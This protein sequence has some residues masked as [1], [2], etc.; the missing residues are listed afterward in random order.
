M[1]DANAVMMIT[2]RSKSS[3]YEFIK[4]LQQM[5]KEENPN[6]FIINGKIPIQYFN[7]HVLNIDSNESQV[8]K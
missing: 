7:K 4:K 3:A 6:S 1:Y 2:G 5:L 8:P